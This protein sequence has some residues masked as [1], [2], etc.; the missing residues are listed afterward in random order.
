V[1]SVECSNVGKGQLSKAARCV[2]S[3]MRVA[4]SCYI[5][6]FHIVG[7]FRFPRV[8][9]ILTTKDA[10]F[11]QNCQFIDHI[12]L[13]DCLTQI[14]RTSKWLL[15]LDTTE[16]VDSENINLKIGHGSYLYQLFSKRDFYFIKCGWNWQKLIFFDFFEK[17]AFLTIFVAITSGLCSTTWKTW[18]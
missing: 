1:Q 17:V 12:M 4:H 16:H 9:W 14:R 10:L 7:I 3:I 8:V 15:F 18:K 11:T 2:L 6:T 13:R 5:R